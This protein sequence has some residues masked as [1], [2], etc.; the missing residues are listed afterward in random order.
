MYKGEEP[1]R[2]QVEIITFYT[3]FSEKR[4]NAF[5]YLPLGH[6]WT[7]L[8]NGATARSNFSGGPQELGHGPQHVGPSHSHK[9]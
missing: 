5:I 3:Q 1:K 7:P 8:T 9:C 6:V 2:P 4:E